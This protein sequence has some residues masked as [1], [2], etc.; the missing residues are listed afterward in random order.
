LSASA[1]AAIN[2]NPTDMS[3]RIFFSLV[4]SDFG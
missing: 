2:I 4:N 3:K 1:G